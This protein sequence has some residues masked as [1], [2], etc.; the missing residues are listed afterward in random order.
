MAA[1]GEIVKGS[2]LGARRSAQWRPA[3]F[4][5]ADQ[6]ALTIASSSGASVQQKIGGGPGVTG[7]GGLE[8]FDKVLLPPGP[9]VGDLTVPADIWRVVGW[10]CHGTDP[11]LTNCAA[12]GGGVGGAGVEAPSLS[13]DPFTNSDRSALRIEDTAT[14]GLTFTE[15]VNEVCTAA[16]APGAP[17]NPLGSTCDDFLLLDGLP[18]LLASIFIP[19]NTFLGQSTE[20]FLDLRLDPRGGALVCTG[21]PFTDPAL[22][23]GYSGPL[24]VIYTAENDVNSVAVQGRLVFP[25]VTVPDPASLVLLGAGLMGGALATGISRRRR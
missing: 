2:R 14:L 18:T 8:L 21:N 1:G 5:L 6:Q 10:G 12:S 25:R 11:L 20:F 13:G 19:G 7:Q 17:V 4:A 15:T 23:G 3:T 9:P 22:C 16:P 24:T